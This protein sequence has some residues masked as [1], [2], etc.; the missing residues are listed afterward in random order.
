MGQQNR[1][2]VKGIYEAFGGGDVDAI[3][4]AMAEE[5]D[6]YLP[7]TAPYSGRRHG[8]A[9]VRSFFQEL[10]VELRFERFEVREYIADRD[11]VMAL[12]SERAT[13]F[14]TGVQYEADWAHCW[15]LNSGL[16]TAVQLYVDTGAEAAAFAGAPRVRRASSGPDFEF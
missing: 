1:N 4:N 13:V 10:A 2:L 9:Q 5:V 11:K 8:R 14:S 7:G 6:W 3:V 16:V 15:T 12:G